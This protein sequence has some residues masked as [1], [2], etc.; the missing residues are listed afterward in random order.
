MDVVCSIVVLIVSYCLSRKWGV[1][2]KCKMAPEAA[3][4][5]PIFGH[6][7][8][9]R[10]SPTPS[11]VTLGAMA[12][13]YGPIFTLRLGSHRSLVV[14]SSEMAKACFIINDL[15]LASRPNLIIAEHVGYGYAMFG[16]S[17]RGPFWRDFRKIATLELLS[18]R[19]LELLKHIRVSELATFLKELHKH[20]TNTERNDDTDLVEMKQWLWELSLNVILWMVAG[21]RYN[22]ASNNDINGCDQVWYV[23]YT[24]NPLL[25]FN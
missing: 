18:N 25:C 7:P 20:W 4:G 17:P 8:L 24:F 14:S 15:S 22:S 13:Q 5:W 10:G 6:L 3:G 16:F 11:H 19:R 23:Y 2:S 21:K 9:L 1:G 12:D